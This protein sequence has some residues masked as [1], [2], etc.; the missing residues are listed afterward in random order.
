MDAAFIQDL[1]AT[2]QRRQRPEDVADMILSR[3]PDLFTDAEKAVLEAAARGALR[4]LADRASAMSTD[5]FKAAPPRRQVATAA[6]LFRRPP[7]LTPV[8]CADPQALKA[9]VTALSAE[10]D[11]SVGASSF[12]EDRLNRAG[13]KAHGLDHSRRRYNKLFRFLRRL[14]RK[15]AAYE[16][17][18]DNSGDQMLAKSGLASR[19]PLED[20]QASPEAACFVAYYVARR[21]RR[22]VFTNLGQDPAFDEIGQMLL[23]RFKRAA[24]PGGWRMIAQVAPDPEAIAQLSEPDRLELLAGWLEAMRDIAVRMGEVWTQNQF[25]RRAMI[26]AKGDGSSAWNALAGAWNISR[27]GWLTA[28]A[29]LDMD[30][31]LDRVCLGKAMRLMAGDV[32]A[33]H[34]ALH[35]DTAVWAELPPPW[36]VFLGEATC[37]RSDVE[38][39]CA[40]HDVD[41]VGSGW[42]APRRR[43]EPVPF[44]PTPE[45]VHGVAVSHP[46]LAVILR[47]AGWFSGKTARP[48]PAGAEVEVRRDEEGWVLGASAAKP[49]FWRRLIGKAGGPTGGVH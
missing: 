17:Q 44:Q 1:H 41:P 46:E 10:I 29:A 13:R 7:A 49:G 48:L 25:D 26:V 31:M 14:E 20:F 11:K 21:N 19:I 12:K 42:I 27:Q 32:A 22:S 23:E 8:E 9:F 18:L 3:A 37:T 43:T 30:D 35:P 15:I 36:E 39:A 16:R 34:D 28:V 24:R 2:L 47:K 6:G 4:R 33:W 45:L 5:F 40:R 38:I